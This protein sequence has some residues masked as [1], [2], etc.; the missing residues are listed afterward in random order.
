MF[1]GGY[2]AHRSR[3]QFYRRIRVDRPMGDE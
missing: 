3:D 1:V 2:P